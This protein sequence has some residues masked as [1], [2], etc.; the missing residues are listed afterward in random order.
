MSKSLYEFL[1]NLNEAGYS[2]T[3]LVKEIESQLS[4]ARN[5]P[6][7]ANRYL[8]IARTSIETGLF[9]LKAYE[10]ETDSVVPILFDESEDS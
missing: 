8:S 2:M 1:H 7:S 9:Y 10:E 3:Q 4:K 6:S 5:N